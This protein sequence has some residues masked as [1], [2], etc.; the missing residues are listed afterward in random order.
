MTLE[1]QIEETNN[2]SAEIYLTN[3]DLERLYIYSAINCTDDD[4]M[5]V[6]KHKT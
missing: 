3:D 5:I 1:N 2:N 4:L 6:W